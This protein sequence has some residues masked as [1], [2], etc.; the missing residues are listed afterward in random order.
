MKTQLNARVNPA[1]VELIKLERNGIP[2]C[3]SDGEALESMIFGAATS[4]QARQFNTQADMKD[5]C[6]AADQRVRE[7]HHAKH[8]SRKICNTKKIRLPSR[9]E[10]WLRWRQNL[11][12]HPSTSS[13]GRWRASVA[14][15][16][17]RKMFPAT[18]FTE[19]K[20]SDRTVK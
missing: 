2:G 6:L 10:R 5:R 7:A 12:I 8:K 14:G 16:R 11:T 18:G 17:D 3:S 19:L 15:R 4:P 1:C 9:T 13:Y 20:R